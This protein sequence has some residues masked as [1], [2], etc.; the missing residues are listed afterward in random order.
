MRFNQKSQ[1]YEPHARVQQALID[2]GAAHWYPQHANERVLELGAGTGLLTRLLCARGFAVTAT[3]I[4]ENMIT[5]GK[6]YCPQADWQRLD[7][8]SP[9]VGNNNYTLDEL[10]YDTLATSALLQWA[11]CPRTVLNQWRKYVKPGGRLLAL[12]FCAPSLPELNTLLPTASPLIWRSP[13]AWN[14]AA[15]EAGW[16][17]TESN[18]ST[19]SFVYPDTLHF[20]RNLHGTGA[21]GTPRIPPTTLRKCLA[22]YTEQNAH[23]EGV[24]ATWTFMKIEA[25]QN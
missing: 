8:W 4:A 16:Q 13:D 7:A 25:S 5:T 11:P 12:L 18:H 15:V 20:F 14:T 17:I 22:D 1:S 21:V 23:P 24:H 2:W 6:A 19:Q 3:D 9:T 10:S